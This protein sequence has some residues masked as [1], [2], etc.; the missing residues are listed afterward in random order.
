MHCTLLFCNCFVYVRMRLIL[1]VVALVY[2]H[3][4]CYFY[5]TERYS[6]SPV[7]TATPHSN[8]SLA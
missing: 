2:L 5:K 3:C 7:L 4:I 6:S 1:Y 8:G